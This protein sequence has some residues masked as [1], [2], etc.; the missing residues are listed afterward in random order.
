MSKKTTNDAESAIS[1]NKTPPTKGSQNT[2]NLSAYL[3]TVVNIHPLSYEVVVSV[4]G[5]KSTM[6]ALWV[7]ALLSSL[8]GLTVKAFP[9]IGQ[10]VLV[11]KNHNLNTGESWCMGYFAQSDATAEWMVTDNFLGVDEDISFPGTTT[12]NRGNVSGTTKNTGHYPKDLVDGEGSIGIAHGAA[13][14]FLQNLVRLR[15]SDLAKIEAYTIDD[16][17]RIL[18]QNFEHLSAFGDFKILNNNGALDVIWRGTCNEHETFNKDQENEDKDIT[19]KN[20]SIK[21]DPIQ[22]TTLQQ[23]AKWRFQQY[24]GKLGSFIHTFITEPQKMVGKDMV[25]TSARSK[26]YNGIDG[27]FLVQSVSD[28]AF[29]KVICIPVPMLNKV[30]EELDMASMKLDAFEQWQYNPEAL[31][32]TS[33]QFIDYGR[34]LGNYFS[35]A[36]FHGLKDATVESEDEH[37]DVTL[38]VGDEKLKSAFSSLEDSQ[39]L[40]LTKY[41]TIRIF[42]DGSIILVNGEGCAVHM[43]GP[44]LTFSSPRDINIKAAGSVNIT[45]NN[46][47]L[48]ARKR[49]DIVSAL[50]GIS[51]KAQNWL[52]M[53]CEKGSILLQS[54]MPKS[55]ESPPQIDEIQDTHSDDKFIANYNKG[56]NGGIVLRTKTS[57]IVLDSGHNNIFINCMHYINSAF[58]AVFNAT[59]FLIK[60]VAH[61][62]KWTTTIGSS[63]V[64]LKM[65]FTNFIS[66]KSAGK[67]VTTG[68]DGL[69]LKHDED[70]IDP[71][72]LNGKYLKESIKAEGSTSDLLDSI[73]KQ[74]EEYKDSDFPNFDFGIA[75]DTQ[76]SPDYSK[77]YQTI[78]EQVIASSTD[79]EIYYTEESWDGILNQA[80]MT[81]RPLYPPP[82]YVKIGYRAQNKI[83]EKSVLAKNKP[84]PTSMTQAPNDFFAKQDMYEK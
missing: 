7:S 34:W 59:Q 75:R 37:D 49:I 35:L 8:T 26:I 70:K 57:N 32:E 15:A 51:I 72:A 13:I 58:S 84:N 56:L 74:G 9:Q 2:P 83:N 33:Y 61:F 21:L 60:D 65:L 76:Q 12:A 40:L 6:V 14:D 50:R 17:I 44:D 66:N 62:T 22:E 81:G 52:E 73:F 39:D 3:G 43:A 47:N 68:Q 80:P 30:P 16:F 64:N 24:I 20:N 77:Q 31:Y 19:V 48:L 38:G 23:D 79:N 29:E 10:Q 25:P 41:A 27:T 46:V 54:F 67:V 71:D 45:G 1:S 55:Y 4:D 18:S 11:L 36:A 69:T 53:A 28:I 78:S 42:K 5:G 63:F 82:S